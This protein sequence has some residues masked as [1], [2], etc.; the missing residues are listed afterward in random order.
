MQREGFVPPAMSRRGRPRNVSLKSMKGLGPRIHSNIRT[1][2]KQQIITRHNF[3]MYE[4]RT[5]YCQEFPLFICKQAKPYTCVR[6]HYE[7]NIRRRPRLV[8]G[9][10]N[11]TDKLCSYASLT[12]CPQGMNCPFSHRVQKEHIY[13]PSL[14]KTQLC[15]SPLTPDGT[16]A[17]FGLHCAKAHGEKDLREPQ[18]EPEDPR[19]ASLAAKT[20]QASKSPS[21]MGG[22]RD[23]KATDGALPVERE[24]DEDTKEL[25]VHS[26]YIYKFRVRECPKHLSGRCPNDGHLCF[27]SHNPEAVRRIPQLIRG[28]FNY[29]PIRCQYMLKGKTCHHAQNCRFAHSKEEVIYHPSK[30]KTQLC[31]HRL[32]RTVGSNGKEAWVCGGYGIHCAKAH[33]KDDLRLPVFENCSKEKT[34]PPRGFS[35][36]TSQFRPSARVHYGHG[37]PYDTSGKMGQQHPQH[38]HHRYVMYRGMDRRADVQS[39]MRSAAGPRRMGGPQMPHQSMDH[40]VNPQGMPQTM[41]QRYYIGGGHYDSGPRPQFDH[42]SQAQQSYSNGMASG[43]IN[44]HSGGGMGNSTRNPSQ[45]QYNVGIHALPPPVTRNSS[46]GVSNESL[47]ALTSTSVSTSTSPAVSISPAR[48]SQGSQSRGPQGRGGE[49]FSSWPARRRSGSAPTAPIGRPSR[50]TTSAADAKNQARTAQPL[51]QP[52]PRAQQQPSTPWGSSGMG[53]APGTQQP[54]QQQSDQPVRRAMRRRSS[55]PMPFVNKPKIPFGMTSR[56]ARIQLEMQSAADMPLNGNGGLTMAMP[57]TGGGGLTMAVPDKGG[58][59]LTMAVPAPAQQLGQTPQQQG[60]LKGAG[61]K[62]GG[63]GESQLE[64]YLP[65]FLVG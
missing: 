22:L 29:L 56:L 55:F 7:N 38:Q 9:K 11:F 51:A 19:L 60:K 41:Q 52:Q 28:K 8:N 4:F 14:Y 46:W 58:D 50:P 31:P 53:A 61:G 34:K 30:Y 27:D 17:E 18:Y 45:R 12:D 23:G 54:Q 42:S 65:S 32:K 57:D 48:H 6:A 44:P 15:E 39:R 37:R 25:K 47:E 33:G 10:F 43:D 26:D 24:F 36:E 20:R 62:A 5:K 35:P 40:R 49:A 2:T 64:A 3:Y 59:G 21:E 1:A 16:C 13:H 63:S